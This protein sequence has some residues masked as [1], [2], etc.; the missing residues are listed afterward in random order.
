MKKNTIYLYVSLLLFVSCAK[1]NG[2]GAAS[3]GGGDADRPTYTVAP[4]GTVIDYSPAST[5]VYLGSPSIAILSDGTYVAS[6][7]VFGPGSV[8]TPVTTS[9]FRSIDRGATWSLAS[10][11]EYMTWGKLFVHNDILYLMGMEAGFRPCRLLSSDD[12]GKTWSSPSIIVPWN[13]H[14][15]SVPVVSH[16]GRLWRGLEV[17]NPEIGTWPQQFNAMIISVPLDKN[18]MESA[19]WTRSNQLE[20]DSRYLNGL[21]QGWLEGN[22]VPGPDNSMK[23]IMRVQIPNSMNGEKIA[24][25]DVSKDGKTISFDPETDFVNMPGGAKK[26]CIRYDDVSGRYWTL[27]NYVKPEYQTKNPADIRNTI[28]LCSSVD[29]RNWTVNK[30]ILESDDYEKTGFQYVDWQIDGDDIV[31]VSRTAHDDGNGGASSSHDNNFFT[32]HKVEK[33]RTL[34]DNII[35]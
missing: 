17:K 8:G 18:I 33:F 27:S 32:F 23:L 22:A 7:D 28:A 26:F 11:V 13:C 10:K 19:N 12:G 16:D 35:K 4:P 34:L 5:R 21:F 24:I 25:I 20:Y 30:L 2:P 31:F 9:V 29:L 1:E 6:H 14:S 15:S 3:G